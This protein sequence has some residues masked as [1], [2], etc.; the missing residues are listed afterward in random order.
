VR[1][2]STF[3]L[4]GKVTILGNKAGGTIDATTVGDLINSVNTPSDSNSTVT[5][6]V[7]E[8]T[9]SEGSASNVYLAHGKQIEVVGAVDAT[10]SIGVLP[11]GG[12]DKEFVT[13][14]SNAGADAV[15]TVFA[16]DYGEYAATATSSGNLTW[17]STHEHEYIYTVLSDGGVLETCSKT[18]CPDPQG[19]T[20]L[21]DVDNA[22]YSGTAH[23][24]V[25][26]GNFENVD[27]SVKYY[28]S[29][30]NAARANQTETTSTVNAGYYT[31]VLYAGDE[32]VHSLSFQVTKVDLI[33]T[34]ND[35][36]IYY[37][38][39]PADA[40]VTY[41]GF[42]NGE[43]QAV[44]GG[45]LQYAHGY[46]R[47]D[48]TGI[49]GITPAGLTSTNYNIKFERGFLTVKKLPVTATVAA[50]SSEY[51]SELASIPVTITLGATGYTL[52]AADDDV[53]A[54]IQDDII[55]MATLP[56]G[57]T[58][59]SDAATYNVIVTTINTNYEVTVAGNANA[60]TIK[61]ATA[62]ISSVTLRGWTYGETPNDP[63]AAGATSGVV[64]SYSTEENGNYTT[65]RPTNAGTYWVKASV[66]GTSNTEASEQKAKF[67]IAKK[68]VNEPAEQPT[69]YT[70]TGEAIEYKVAASDYYTVTGNKQTKIGEDY[71]VTIS[72]NDPAN[73]VWSSGVSD[74]ITRTFS[75]TAG[76]EE[77]SI[78]WLIIVLGI[79]LVIELVAVAVFWARH[80]SM[81]DS[82]PEEDTGKVNSSALGIIPLILAASIPSWQV[83]VVIVLAIAIVL[84][85]LINIIIILK[86]KGGLRIKYIE[87][88]RIIYRDGKAEVDGQEM[89]ITLVNPNDLQL[90][91]IPTQPVF[92]SDGTGELTE[93][94]RSVDKDTGMATI[95]RFRKS[96]E[97]KYIQASDEAKDYYTALKNEILSYKKT[98]SRVSWNYDNIMYGRD[99]ILR[100]NVRGK[101]LC[102]YFA[103]DP[104]SLDQDKYKVERSESKRYEDV[105]CLY[106]IK[107]QRRVNLAIELMSMLA[108]KY[109]MK[110]GE[111]QH[112]DYYVHYESTESLLQR[113]LIK[114]YYIH[115]KYAD[116]I[117]KRKEQTIVE[118][119]GDEERDN[120]VDD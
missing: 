30:T 94:L 28:Y 18:N 37:A 55:V 73:Y 42:V 49:Y 111:D 102:L 6:A 15:T 117:R 13:G 4:E 119:E 112:G 93:V 46:S 25:L 31:A 34:A 63:V 14:W 51:G 78:L 39:A 59:Y 53:N 7:P 101:T 45:T 5:Q 12:Y 108:E 104:D 115:E 88:E 1:S 11:A 17:T 65:V 81:E 79:V 38:Y 92:M 57:V 80:R 2:A 71:K 33:I 120:S 56:A 110:R 41:D 68:V 64:Y 74:N 44:L 3:Q 61:K 86:N 26:S 50:T 29:A 36:T 32:E 109:G 54:K 47:Y 22:S 95:I 24:A 83:I 21:M 89:A 77:V 76:D 105:P 27:H 99:S 113:R 67:T 107:N 103:L 58:K 75:I 91:T 16:A 69:T 70:Y 96:F 116:Y 43:T 48:S 66:A 62:Q 23:D 97:A 87:K 85:A 20:V 60:Y 118:D 19:G 84:V 90:T 72:L 35:N 106:R 8:G 52:P 9:F 100:F 82:E 40:G 98:R 10:S 114:E